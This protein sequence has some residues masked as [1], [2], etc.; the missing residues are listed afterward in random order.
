MIVRFLFP[1]DLF[2]P[3]QTFKIGFADYFVACTKNDEENILTC[4]QASKLGAKHVQLVINKSDYDKLINS[5]KMSDLEYTIFML[6]IK[7][8]VV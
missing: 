4:I 3:P 6:E 7:K 1:N 8:A 2:E 5:L